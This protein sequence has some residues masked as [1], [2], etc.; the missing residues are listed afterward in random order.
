MKDLPRH[1]STA[2]NECI[3]PSTE[4]TSTAKAILNPPEDSKPLRRCTIG[5]GG[6]VDTTALVPVL[7]VLILSY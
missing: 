7:L 2:V 4:C 1:F 6:A 3:K 5:A